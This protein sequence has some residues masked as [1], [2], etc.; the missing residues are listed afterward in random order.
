MSKSDTALPTKQ[1]LPT[2]PRRRTGVR[3]A[4]WMGLLW[5]VVI[6]VAVFPFPWWW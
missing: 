3:N 4:I 2:E 1:P 5:L 6:V